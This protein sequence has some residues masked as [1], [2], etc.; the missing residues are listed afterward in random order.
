MCKGENIVTDLKSG[1]TN[2]K[3]RIHLNKAINIYEIHPEYSGIYLWQD[4]G[5]ILVYSD[6]INELQTIRL[7]DKNHNLVD[8]KTFGNK[9]VVF[10]KDME[11]GRYTVDLNVEDK[12][13][14]DFIV[15]IK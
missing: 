1:T 8:E 3:Y 4:N 5:R 10:D 12:W 6:Q 9:V 14:T 11:P 13:I 7:W 15:E 2:D